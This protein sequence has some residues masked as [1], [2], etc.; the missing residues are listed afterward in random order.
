MKVI[1]AAVAA[2]LF[3]AS[4]AA[5]AGV[6]GIVVARSSSALAIAAP[7]GVVHTVRVHSAARVGSVVTLSGSRVAVVGLAHRVRFRGIVV[8]NVGSTSFLAAGGMLLAVHA[9][10]R[11]LAAV[12]DTGPTPGT[13]VNTTATVGANGTL[14]QQSSQTVGQ[15]GTVSVQATVTSVGAGTV[16]ITVNGQALTLPLPAG[17]TLPSTIV[18]STVTLSLNL[19]GGTATATAEDEDQDDQGDDNDDQGDDDSD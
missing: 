9:H 4:P 16:T 3:A 7:S 2:S 6:K 17:L 18:G 1:L 8:R 12:G 15:A 19:G 11:H 10:G 5:A 14:T 13:V